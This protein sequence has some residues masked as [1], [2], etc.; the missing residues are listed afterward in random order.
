MYKHEKITW[1]KPGTENL[2]P[3]T[4]GP[5]NSGKAEG[6]I[7]IIGGIEGGGVAHTSM[8]EIFIVNGA[9]KIQKE[10]KS[11]RWAVGLLGVEGLRCVGNY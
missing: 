11:E 9:I 8:K 3:A 5:R 6:I 2:E 4:I 1:L 7:R 10:C